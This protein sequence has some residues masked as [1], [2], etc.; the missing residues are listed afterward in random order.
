M[1]ATPTNNRKNG[2]METME[3]RIHR[4]TKKERAARP[5]KK[6]RTEYITITVSTPHAIYREVSVHYSSNP[7][8]S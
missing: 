4:S 1:G 2:K 8:T 6:T 7:T 5:T 3:A